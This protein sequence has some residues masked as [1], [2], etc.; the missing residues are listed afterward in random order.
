MN[1]A[2]NLNDRLL[3]LDVFRG[4]TV[5]AMIL[6]N[7][8]GDWGHIY[9][10]L[11]HAAW[12]GCTPADLIFPF[13]LFIVGVSISFSLGKKAIKQNHSQLLW[14]VAKRALIL[15]GLGLFLAAF[16]FVF[17]DPI[18]TLK[19]LRI[20]GILQR[21][22][23]V[24]F[25]S[26]VIFIKTTPRTQVIVAATLLV[27]Y[28]LMMTY[29][30]VPGV[31]YANFEKETNLGAWLDR[32]ILGEAHLWKLSITWDPE[33]LLST[34]PAIS[35]GLLG[36]LAGNILKRPDYPESVKVAWIFA[37]G[38]IIIILGLLWHL[39]FPINK[40]LWTS[41]YVLY[42]GGLAMLGLALCYW[43]IDVQSYKQWTKPFV[44][45]GV[46][47]LA[48]FFFSTLVAKL[49]NLPLIYNENGMLIST[50]SYL[51]QLIF[52]SHL[53]AFDASLAMGCTYILV[54]L[55]ILWVMYVKKV[56]IKI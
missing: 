17:T 24:F 56:I 33:G 46:N 54:W 32:A 10:P 51:Y 20:P 42:T 43:L 27:V 4:I 16:P 39:I 31:G 36:V 50:K 34:L 30:P 21:I 26:A 7:N 18:G 28:W 6:V 37:L 35:T 8:P 12:N 48:A 15:F 45:Y 55:L 1:I 49:L 19:E 11:A 53:S 38:C 41:S 9:A 3:S 5:A 23:I 47:A 40:A 44:V 22:A 29:V 52:A 25:I 2:Q 14:L 13:F